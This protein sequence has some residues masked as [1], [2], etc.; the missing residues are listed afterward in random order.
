MTSPAQRLANKRYRARNAERCN[1][2]NAKSYSKRY[3]EDETMRTLKKEYVKEHYKQNCNY[4][5][6]TNMAVSFKLLF[7]E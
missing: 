3:H 6:I 5:D 2:I 7:K 4:R 1:A